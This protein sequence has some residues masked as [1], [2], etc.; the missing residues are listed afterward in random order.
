L[1]IIRL[2]LVSASWWW[3]CSAGKTA[4]AMGMAKALGEETPFA[5][6]A[7]S[8]IF[9]LE[10]SK[11][12]ALTQVGPHCYMLASAATMVSDEAALPLQSIRCLQSGSNIQKIK[13]KQCQ[14]HGD[15]LM[16]ANATAQFLSSRVADALQAALC[17]ELPA[18]Q[19]SHHMSDQIGCAYTHVCSCTYVFRHSGKLSAY[20]S[21]KKPKLL[22]GR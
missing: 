2:L 5:M 11:T 6:M 18:A 8:E 9:S 1:D 19:I 14:H 13:T 12:E 21:R 3:S 7:A 22:K 17:L 10:M 16:P 15:T 20:A 4:I